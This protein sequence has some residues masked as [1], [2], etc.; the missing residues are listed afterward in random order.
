MA[1]RFPSIPETMSDREAAAVLGVKP[2][3]LA[4]WRSRRHPQIPYTKC[5]AK[6]R[7]FVADIAEFLEKN[8]HGG[9]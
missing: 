3:T 1:A 4:C 8:R 5:G 6:V 7:Y 9:E 2:G